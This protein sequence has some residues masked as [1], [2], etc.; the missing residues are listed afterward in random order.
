[1]SHDSQPPPPPPP[2]PGLFGPKRIEPATL[3]RAILAE[4]VQSPLVLVPLGA[5]ALAAVWALSMGA[6]V[7]SI[8]AAVGGVAAG[9]VGALFNLL[10]RGEA[11]RDRI[12]ARWT[13]QTA[14]EENAAREALND[15][16]RRQLDFPGTVA[17]WDSLES[18]Y[19]EAAAAAGRLGQ[20]QVTVSLDLNHEE[21]LR[22]FAELAEIQAQLTDP[23]TPRA[24]GSRLSDE[25]RRLTDHLKAL[26]R[27]Y[28]RLAT[29]LPDVEA[30]DDL[31]RASRRLRELEDSI[32]AAG[33]AYGSL[34]SEDRPGG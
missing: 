10:V 12:I 1:M 33:R 26:R 19:A 28:E 21:A 25:H 27:N 6:D 4:T 2:G 3:R 31:D 32:D 30:D 11:I 18:G 9:T 17:L 22:L 23:G 14:G 20:A 29:D 15:R 34:R 24:T 5:A 13:H 8:M 7:P 16:L